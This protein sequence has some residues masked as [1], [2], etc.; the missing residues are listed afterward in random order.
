MDFVV[1]LIKIHRM[2]TLC[3][4][5]LFL[6]VSCLILVVSCRKGDSGELVPDANNG[7]ISLP[8]GFAALVVADSIGPGRHI[9]VNT[10]G[11]IYLALRELK[12]GHG[13]VAMRDTTGDGKADVMI[14]FGTL[15]GTGLQIHKGYLYFAHDRGVI[16][17]KLTG[18]LL[19]D[20]APETIVTGFTPQFQ[21][22]AKTIAFDT[23]G[24]LYVNVGAPS[25]A[26]QE[27][28]RTPGSPGIDPCPILENYGGI[29][30]FRDDVPNQTQAVHGTRFATGLRNCVAIDW[31]AAVNNL[32][33]VQHGRDQLN[34]LFPDI[35]N[36]TD[37][38]DLPA[39]EFFML[40]EGDDCG[41]P[42]CYYDGLQ[43]VKVL[44]PEYGGDGNIVG[45]CPEKKDPLMAFP[46]HTAPND[47]LFYSGSMFP[48]RYKNGAFIAFHGSWNRSPVEQ[49]G[50]YVAFVPFGGRMPVDTWEIFADGFAGKGPV[51][52]PGDAVHRPMGLAMGPDGSLYI[53]DSVRGTIWRIFHI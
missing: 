38:A 31:N 51:M 39:E 1:I 41:W 25:N 43:H 2:K 45:R 19:P 30:R 46:A 10:N 4:K 28:D 34:Q 47:L 23:A 16:R 6:L 27:N 13:L 24:Y 35:Y 33:V 15:P 8:E 36:D 37:N 53:S 32:Y 49:K 18:N 50:Y 40:E 17:Y 21:H 20:M 22:A 5:P 14:R 11:D 9:A 7:A 12:D 48:D 3:S 44:A 26:C 29:W 52:N 42:Y